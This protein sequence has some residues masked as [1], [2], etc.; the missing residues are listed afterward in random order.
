MSYCISP[1]RRGIAGQVAYDVVRE[2]EWTTFVGSIYG[3]PGP[4]VM[5]GHFGEMFVVD[6]SRFGERFDRA[7]IE[8]F[9]SDAR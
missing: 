5:V 9:Y 2:N 4:V 6:S 3:T 7:W 8:R 1:A